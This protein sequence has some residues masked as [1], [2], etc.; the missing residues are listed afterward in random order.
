M[1]SAQI[2]T[3]LVGGGG[4]AASEVVQAAQTFDPAPLTEGVG[5]ITQIIILV[6]TLVGL[7]KKKRV[8]IINFL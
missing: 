6:A 5:I 2:K 7:F 3:I 4:A 8:L 1:Q